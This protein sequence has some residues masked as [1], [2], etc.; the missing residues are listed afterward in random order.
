MS[1]LAEMALE[2]AR[3]RIGEK[4]LKAPTS[5]APKINMPSHDAR[6]RSPELVVIG[7]INRFMYLEARSW[8]TDLVASLRGSP[9]DVVIERLAGATEG[10][11]G[12]YVAGIQS[13]IGKLQ[14]GADRD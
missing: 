14:A 11:P 12:S 5:K 7:P 8:A 10:R 3:Q 2:H 6:P 4:P 1:S 13:V 9:V